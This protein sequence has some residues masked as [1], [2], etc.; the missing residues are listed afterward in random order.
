M[1]AVALV[2]LCAGKILNWN[3]SVRHGLSGFTWAQLG[4]VL[5][6]GA[7]VALG[8]R[9]LRSWLLV[10]STSPGWIEEARLVS[11][12]GLAAWIF[13]PF[14]TKDFFGGNDAHWY[15]YVMVDTLQQARAGVFPIFVGQ[16]PFMFEGVLHP[17]RTAPYYQYLGIFLDLLTA[18]SLPP[19]AIQHLTVL[20]TAMQ[21][22]LACYVALVCLEPARRG[23]AWLMAALY[24]AAPG[25]SAY[26]FGQEM[27]MTFMAFAWLPV[28][29]LGNI[30]LFR[31]DDLFAWACL[32][33]GLALT[34]LCHA[35]V[36]AWAMLGTVVIQGLRLL[37]DGFNAASWRRATWG[38]L[39][40]GG[41]MAYSYWSVKEIS[42]AKP[43]GGLATVSAGLHV[44]GIAAVIRLASTGRWRW[45]MVAAGLAGGLAWL[46]HVRGIELGAMLALAVV[47]VAVFARRA[48]FL[49]GKRLP[50]S[51][52][53]MAL[54]GGLAGLWLGGP[55]P[56]APAL[57]W[58]KQ[59]FPDNLRPLFPNTMVLTALQVGYA[60]WAG[61]AIGILALVAAP[62]RETR[63]LGILG[64]AWVPLL[65]PVPGVS[66]F[67]LEMV[68]PAISGIS[69]DLPYLRYLPTMLVLAPFLGFFGLH[70]WAAA[71]PRL[72][73][74][75][76]ILLC[77][78]LAWS[79]WESGKFARWQRRPINTPEA[80]A[81]Y[82]R[83]DQIR[84]FSFV[85][86][87]LPLSAY[88]T[89]GVV[90]FHRE[91][92]LLRL[93]DPTH[94][95]DEGRGWE[96][97]PVLTLRSRPDETNP[98]WLHLDP[99]PPLNLAPGEHL[100]LRFE[101]FDRDYTGVL[102]F[103]G[104]RGFYREYQLPSAGY[105]AKSFGVAPEKPKILA[106]WND[107][108][109]PQPVE[110]VFLQSA[111]PADGHPFGDFA[112]V[113]IQAYAP[114]ELPVR[115]L[116]LVPFYRAS[117]RLGAPAYLETVRT[118]VP[119]YRARVNG[120]DRPV[121]RSPNARAMVPLPQGDSVVELRYVGTRGLWT[122]MAVTA[123]A[124]LVALT[125]MGRRL[126]RARAPRPA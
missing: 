111:L 61:F 76:V 80:V 79:L 88:L 68:P 45:A 22:A 117:A 98:L 86:G 99:D 84:E 95:V 18:Q 4:W 78:G 121:V 19:V 1:A 36:A 11:L 38:G 3:L 43:S 75:F 57:G 72:G 90:D 112:R 52:A 15:G 14:L 31:E 104:P 10:R 122:T 93:D 9:I 71:R 30:L 115:T 120:R 110:I 54:A 55:S 87:T 108:A 74:F 2:G 12:L 20:G 21:G 44:L 118:F 62:T 47:G 48:D 25:L 13:R 69:S 39:L 116:G 8:L 85:T 66:R 60:L 6:A 51:I 5:L 89:S 107:T 70:A 53:L 124:W 113:A 17:F 58:V 41:L 105:F 94:E 7:V 77:G 96:K 81:A 114:D 92:R 40:L 65:V 91:S 67:L 97:T 42:A 32:G 109:E 125:T 34:L 126:V 46:D 59:L 106:L 83:T 16:G 23:S 24:V 35:P 63:W 37:T 49:R 103:R 119:G 82:Y 123:V 29:L 101:F 26:I 73:G 56:A 50:E 28:V 33:A 64:L 100:A 27:Y 102:I